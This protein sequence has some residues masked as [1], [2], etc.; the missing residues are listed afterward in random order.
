MFSL[1]AFVV[2]NQV[3]QYGVNV[4]LRSVFGGVDDS[5]ITYDG[6]V[7]P[8]KVPD[9]HCWKPATGAVGL[10][11]SDIPSS[12]LRD[13]PPY[14]VT[15]QRKGELDWV[16]SVGFLGDYDTGDDGAGA[17]AGVDIRAPKGTPVVAMMKGLVVRSTEEPGGFGLYV[18]VKTAN[19]PDPYHPGK[20]VTLYT[21]YAHLSAK[22]VDE[23]SIVEKNQI[24][25]AVGATGFAVGNHLHV[26]MNLGIE[27]DGKE[28][29]QPAWTFTTDEARDAGL[30]FSQAVDEG[31]F[32]ERAYKEQVNPILY[33]QARH[34]PSAAVIAQKP[35]K[36]KTT[37]ASRRAERLKVR[38]LNNTTTAVATKQ[39]LQ[40]TVVIAYN[41]EPVPQVTVDTHP[42]PVPALPP[43]KQSS[44]YSTIELRTDGVQ[45]PRRTWTTVELIFLDE[46]GNRVASPA[47]KSDIYLRAAFGQAEFKPARLS[48]FDIVNGTAKVQVLGF[49]PTVLLELKPANIIF[50][51]NPLQFA[52]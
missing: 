24:L 18:T 51:K 33:A 46:N 10:T 29:A 47:L 19:A 52:Q 4:F 2:G 45:V 41:D 17:H 36:P 43:V 23:G 40:P 49:S 26:Q 39:Q 35:A 34:A 5:L 1:M 21:T 14:D 42:A 31:L 12:C 11:Y 48:E 15:L 38:T 9:Y 28:L 6:T 30:S 44:T 25:G 20:N 7:S 16:Y 13:L 50:D 27:R 22:N 3:G 32:Q 8:V 37:V